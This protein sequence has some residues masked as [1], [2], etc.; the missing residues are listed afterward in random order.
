MRLKHAMK[1]SLLPIMAGNVVGCS[2]IEQVFPILALRIFFQPLSIVC[3]EIKLKFNKLRK[4]QKAKP[5]PFPIMVGNVIGCNA[6]KQVFP[7]L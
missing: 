3:P 1:P 2:A 7:M 6:I 5:S 4:K